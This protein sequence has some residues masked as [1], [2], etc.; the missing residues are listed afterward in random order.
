MSSALNPSNSVNRFHANPA[1]DPTFS[2]PECGATNSAVAA[3]TSFLE[4]T[5]TAVAAAAAA[6]VDLTY[7]DFGFNGLRLP[8]PGHSSANFGI[9]YFSSTGPGAVTPD[10]TDSYAPIPWD[11][12]TFTSPYHTPSSTN[13]VSCDFGPFGFAGSH[14]AFTGARVPGMTIQRF[15]PQF[16][17]PTSCGGLGPPGDHFGSSSQVTKSK[18]R[19][20]LATL[21]QRRAANIRERRRMFNLN[22][23]FDKLR[24]KV[25]TFAYEKRLSRI[26]TLRLAIMYIA[27]MTDVI[28]GKERDSHRSLHDHRPGVQNSHFPHGSGHGLADGRIP[29]GA[30]HHGPT[31]NNEPPPAVASRLAHLCSSRQV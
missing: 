27:F 19:R 5:N 25:P 10:G 29:W 22:S 4:L 9:T 2:T 28:T 18:P 16:R 1:T 30:G 26:E 8:P 3:A 7:A 6:G 12:P 13:P 24:K 11:G 15:G 31:V 21:A 17:S 20:R 23:A 14:C